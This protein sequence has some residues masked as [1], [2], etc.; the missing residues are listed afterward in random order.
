[1]VIILTAFYSDQFAAQSFCLVIVILFLFLSS[2][3]VMVIWPRLVF[4]SKVFQQVKN[5]SDVLPAS[6]QENEQRS[7]S[8]GDHEGEKNRQKREQ[9]RMAFEDHAA[10]A[11]DRLSGRSDPDVHWAL[12]ALKSDRRWMWNFTWAGMHGLARHFEQLEAI[13]IHRENPLELRP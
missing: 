12:P 5:L 2:F 1:M 9:R 13:G 8:F 7:G 11:Y 10:R 6:E 4:E 3:L